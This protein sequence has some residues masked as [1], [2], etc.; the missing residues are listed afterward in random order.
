MVWKTCREFAKA[1]AE[2][3]GR[4]TFGSVQYRIFDYSGHVGE[5]FLC[6]VHSATEII[7]SLVMFSLPLML[8]EGF[9]P[10]FLEAHARQKNVL[11][12][13]KTDDSDAH[14]ED[15][16]HHKDSHG[17]GH[18]EGH[19]CMDLLFGHDHD[20]LNS[21]ISE[22]CEKFVEQSRILEQ[23]QNNALL[24]LQ[25]YPEGFDDLREAVGMELKNK[26]AQTKFGGG[27]HKTLRS[28]GRRQWRPKSER[29]MTHDRGTM[30]NRDQKNGWP[31]MKALVAEFLD[32]LRKLR[33]KGGSGSGSEPSHLSA[34]DYVAGLNLLYRHRLPQSGCK[35]PKKAKVAF[36]KS[37]DRDSNGNI[38]SGE[39]QK[40]LIDA[41]RNA[42][43][44]SLLD[45]HDPTF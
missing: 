36:L 5:D 45:T 38:G 7:V 44:P 32:L 10:L 37:L 20:D 23:V 41:P 25:L 13:C 2:E 11:L 12:A 14:S 34:D 40:F 4:T 27:V 31:K 18:H 3:Y 29:K 8:V 21:I 9:I 43:R 22:V 6:T 28:F 30:W 19:F 1:G 33:R 26:K 42:N 39:F 24:A 16:H 17:H 35:L 15:H